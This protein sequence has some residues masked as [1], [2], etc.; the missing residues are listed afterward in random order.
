MNPF[1]RW[2]VALSWWL[3]MGLA[4]VYAGCAA[5]GTGIEAAT[6]AARAVCRTIARDWAPE[7]VVM[8]SR[9]VDIA[10][11]DCGCPAAEG[12]TGGTVAP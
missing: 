9:L 2:I 7:I 6:D 4:P 10:A 1:S 3:L 8:L 11:G 12:Q 5:W